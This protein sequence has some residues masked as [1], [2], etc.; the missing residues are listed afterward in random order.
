MSY[1]PDALWNLLNGSINSYLYIQLAAFKGEK[2]PRIDGYIRFNK[3]FRLMR[4]EQMTVII[5]YLW[6]VYSAWIWT[7]FFPMETAY[8]YYRAQ[9]A[10]FG[11]L[12]NSKKKSL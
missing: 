2:S 10:R 3:C 7:M 6:Y 9:K 4:F 12:S 5:L 1:L 11:L 8:K